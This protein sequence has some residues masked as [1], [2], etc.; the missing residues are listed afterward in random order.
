MLRVDY[1]FSHKKRKTEKLLRLEGGRS[2]WQG[3]TRGRGRGR[4]GR[5]NF[6]RGRGNFRQQ[7]ASTCERSG[8]GANAWTATAHATHSSEAN[9]LCNN[10]KEWLLDSGCS[11]QI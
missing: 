6:G 3:S 10:E 2:T 1:F 7:G 4:G 9:G 11:N 5:D 8:K